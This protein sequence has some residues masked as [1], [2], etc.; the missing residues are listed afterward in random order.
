MPS[1]VKFPLFIA[2]AALVLT[3]SLPVA[4]PAQPAATR[5]ASAAGSTGA[6]HVMSLS[7]CTDDLL[8][9]LLPPERIASV[10]YYARAP[11]NLALWPQAARVAVN[12]GT[13]EEVLAA[14]PDLVLTGTFT[15]PATRRVLEDLHVALLEVPP[16]NDFDAIREV[17]RSVAHALRREAAAES[18]LAAMDAT[19][20]SLAQTKPRRDIRVAAWGEGGSIPGKGTLFDAILR[21]AGGTNIAALHSNQAYTSFDIEQLLAARPDV[22]AYPSNIGDTPGRNTERALHPLILQ[23]YT[24]K[25]VAY[26]S[27]L[28]SCGLPESVQAAVSLRRHP[29]SALGAG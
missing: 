27:A 14:K 17:T 12:A 10:S 9:E 20:R 8:L 1:R 2:G 7:M 4:A 29:E 13:A 6:Q 25:R 18:L 28:T 15:T 26:S 19:L 5:P 24:G 21:A 11:S 22:I 16:A 23:L 3:C